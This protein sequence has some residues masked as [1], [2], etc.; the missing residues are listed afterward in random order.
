[1]IGRGDV[2]GRRVVNLARPGADR[3]ERPALPVRRRT[4][5]GRGRLRL[6]TVAGRRSP[7]TGEPRVVVVPEALRVDGTA[8][9]AGRDGL[10]VAAG[11]VA[12]LHVGDGLWRGLAQRRGPGHPAGRVIV[13]ERL[14]QPR[15]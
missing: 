11:V 2:T 10:D 15:S 13:G 1:M 9:V 7:G 6:S 3:V 4:A 12:V 8:R 14:L 5:Q